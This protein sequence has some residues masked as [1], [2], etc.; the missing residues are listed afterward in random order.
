MNRSLMSATALLLVTACIQPDQG[1]PT[2]AGSELFKA[3]ASCHG[4]ALTGVEPT[5]PGLLGLPRD[6]LNLSAHP[7]YL[8]SP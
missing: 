4:S 7:L 1:R 3:C 6:Y 8:T 5:V 2:L